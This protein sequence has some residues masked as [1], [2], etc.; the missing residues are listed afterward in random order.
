[1]VVE[2]SGGALA[3][4]AT[5]V[6]LKIAVF[7]GVFCLSL[8]IISISKNKKN[9]SQ[10]GLTLM[11]GSFILIAVLELFRVMELANGFLPILANQDFI[12]ITVEVL[13]IIGGF[14]LLNY[15]KGFKRE[16]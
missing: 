9:S 3:V 15:L 16:G 13:F 12:E 5:L 4:F 7:L 11:S 1:M 8:L 2:I 6:G 14:G 10:L